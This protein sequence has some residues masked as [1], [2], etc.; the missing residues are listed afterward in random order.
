[1]TKP[2]IKGDKT[3]DTPR[4]LYKQIAQH[5]LQARFEDCKDR[6]KAHQACKSAIEEIINRDYGVVSETFKAMFAA[7][8]GIGCEACIDTQRYAQALCYKIPGSAKVI[9]EIEHKYRTR[10]CTHQTQDA[11]ADCISQMIKNN[12]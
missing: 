11:P 10:T 4:E 12:S 2:L 6:E 7:G 8:D 5:N 3:Q 9:E 1:M